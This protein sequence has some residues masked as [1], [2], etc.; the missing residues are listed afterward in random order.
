MPVIMPAM[1]V[2]GMVLIVVGVIV[3]V[4]AMSIVFVRVMPMLMR[5]MIVS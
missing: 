5:G 3:A 2:S 1:I 4:F